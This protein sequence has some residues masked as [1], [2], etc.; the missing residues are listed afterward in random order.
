M[1]LHDT[2]G[3]VTARILQRS[4]HLRF[5]YLRRLDAMAQRKPGAERM[6]CANVAHALAAMPDDDKAAAMPRKVRYSLT[7]V[8]APNIGIINAC[9]GPLA[10]LRDGDMV[11]L[12]AVAGTLQ[13][14][15]AEEVWNTREVL[16]M[17]NALAHDNRLGMG[18]ELFASMRRNA[19]CAEEGA[20]T[21]L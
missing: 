7:P 19:L 14:L 13:A 18:R 20:C 2:V 6:G 12:D 9:G 11:R 5:A 21:W 8:R 15:V 1:K 3:A 4:V 17:P 10:R 16:A